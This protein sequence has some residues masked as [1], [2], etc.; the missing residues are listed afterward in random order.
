MTGGFVPG[1]RLQLMI[2]GQVFLTIRSW[3]RCVR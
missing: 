1:S 3:Q 2:P